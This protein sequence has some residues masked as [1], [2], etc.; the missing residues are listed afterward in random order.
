MTTLLTQYKYVLNTTSSNN[1][2][3]TTFYLGIKKP[4]NC[5]FLLKNSSQRH[6]VKFS[7]TALFATN[8]YQ[9]KI[10]A[11]PMNFTMK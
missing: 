11:S 5:K 1:N 10:Y 9:I 4:K 3:S 2:K 6:I 7:D 8:S